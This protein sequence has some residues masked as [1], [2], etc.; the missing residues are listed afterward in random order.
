[1]RRLRTWI[2]ALA[3]GFFAGVGISR[4][5]AQ[6]LNCTL[7]VVSTKITSGDK[8]VFEDLSKAMNQF[9]NNRRWTKMRFQSQER[10]PCSMTVDIQ[11]YNS[12][13][14]QIKAYLSIQLRRPCFKSTYSSTVF[15]LIDRDFSFRYMKNDPLNYTDN[16]IGTNLTATLAFYV[17]IIL[18]NYFDSFAPQGGTVFYTQAQNIVM[19][20]Q[21]F[22]EEG[23]RSSERNDNNRYWIAESY[24]NGN[25][26]GIHEVL[27]RYY[28]LGMDMMFDDPATARTNILDAMTL[29]D[30]VNSRKTGGLA[31]VTLFMESRADELV[32]IYQP[33][34]QDEKQKATDLFINLDP[35]HIDTY[36]KIMSGAGTAAR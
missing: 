2:G 29:L 27:Y 18:G 5:E 12:S 25:Y 22:A 31:C 1:M 17:Y 15:N 11:E 8:T 26:A 28:R 24:T 16:S 34:A 3:F 21:S 7:N 4:G 9:V 10:I 33:A 36:R 30:E 13:T 19:Q 20:A 6:E 14:G 23:W 32:N 35:A